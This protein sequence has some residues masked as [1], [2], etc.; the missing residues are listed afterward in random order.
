MR[1]PGNTKSITER[2]N[3]EQKAQKKIDPQRNGNSFVI[4]NP[5]IE[6]YE[7]FS[8]PY[9][10]NTKEKNDSQDHLM[11]SICESLHILNQKEGDDAI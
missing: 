1:I 7:D 6:K 8:S 11:I 2:S 5:T 10:L 3:Y 9:P 4:N